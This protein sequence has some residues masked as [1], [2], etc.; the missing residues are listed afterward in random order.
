M[1]GYKWNLLEDLMNSLKIL[2]VNT[3]RIIDKAAKKSEI[4]H[5]F[6]VDSYPYKIDF[7]VGVAVMFMPDAPE[8]DLQVDVFSPYGD[9]LDKVIHE[10]EPDFEKVYISADGGVVFEIRMTPSDHIAKTSGVYTVR[11]SLLGENGGVLDSME[12]RFYLSNSLRE[13]K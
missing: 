1:S 13:I 4:T 7:S 9:E 8:F 10:V 2:S 5:K 11:A 3:G 12:T 6:I